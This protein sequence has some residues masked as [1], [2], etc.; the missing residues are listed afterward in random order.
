MPK[1]KKQK[2][3][4]KKLP[5]PD[6]ADRNGPE[7]KKDDDEVEGHISQADAWLRETNNWKRRR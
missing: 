4:S 2:I 6:E 3:E 7:V 5:S 1:D